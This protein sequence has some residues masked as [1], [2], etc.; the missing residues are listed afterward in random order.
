MNDVLIRANGLS[1]S[2]SP[3]RPVLRGVNLKLRKAERVA[4]T[5]PNG[6]GKSTL[7]HI[8]VGL[9]SPGSGELEAFGK[10]R[11]NERDFEEVRARAGLLFQDPDDQL[12]CPT[13]FEDVAFGP[14]N[15][16][17]R[18]EEAR[19]N[20]TE[21]LDRLGLTGYESRVTYRLSGGEKRLVSLAT[22][23]AMEPEVLLLDEPTAGLDEEATER[24]TR[25]LNGL[26]SSMLIVSQDRDF[27][28]DT[29]GRR[30]SLRDG[31]VNSD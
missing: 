31:S 1:F 8:I 23:L 7:L 27:L 6:A 29:T 3:D 17:K 11:R 26:R 4:L 12:F 19:Q 16:G 21:T 5:G 15:L 10:P 14:L 18:P 2:Y 13:V 22:V 25:V 9:L 30:L 28:S 24:V 20:V